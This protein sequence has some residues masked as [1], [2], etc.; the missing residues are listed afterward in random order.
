[1][2]LNGSN[3][4]RLAAFLEAAVIYRTKI[5]EKHFRNIFIYYELIVIEKYFEMN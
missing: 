2:Q 3:L 1:V 4:R 5:I